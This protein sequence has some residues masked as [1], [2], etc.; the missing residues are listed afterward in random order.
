MQWSSE[1]SLEELLGDVRMGL[2]KLRVLRLHVGVGEELRAWRV[3]MVVGR[4]L[5]GPVEITKRNKMNF[6]L[7]LAPASLI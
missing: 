6:L 5:R 2:R 1:N 3:H 4:E 7:E